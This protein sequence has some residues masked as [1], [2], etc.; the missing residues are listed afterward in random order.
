MYNIWNN[1]NLGRGAQNFELASYST[2]YC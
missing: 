2:G 1:G